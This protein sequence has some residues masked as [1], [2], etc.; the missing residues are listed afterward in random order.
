MGYEGTEI[1]T[2]D[3]LTIEGVLLKQSDPLMMRS[4]GGLTQIIPA[5]RVAS[6]RRLPGSLMMSA[7]HLGLTN[8]DV[9]DLVAFLS[10]R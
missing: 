3:G 10:G 7:A 4:M 1:K 8:Q 2:T 5:N 6:R 9:A